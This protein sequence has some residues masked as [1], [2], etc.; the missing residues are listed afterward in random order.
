MNKPVLT[1]HALGLG[2]WP[3]SPL[4]FL[5]LDFCLSSGVGHTHLLWEPS[6]EP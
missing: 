2:L 3:N 1:P 4:L 5:H 6:P